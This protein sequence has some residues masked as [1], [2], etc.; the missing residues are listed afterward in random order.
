RFQTILSLDEGKMISVGRVEVVFTGDKLEDNRV[1]LGFEERRGAKV[2]GEE[3][4][5]VFQGVLLEPEGRVGGVHVEEEG[6][7]FQMLDTTDNGVAFGGVVFESK[8]E[9]VKVLEGLIEFGA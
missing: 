7:T 1:L 5:A 3:C 8:F 6:I 9:V 2:G 4:R